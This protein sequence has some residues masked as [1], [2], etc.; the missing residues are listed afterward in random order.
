MH[1]MES[2]DRILAVK[3]ECPDAMPQYTVGHTVRIAELEAHMN[4][5]PGLH[6]AGNA[7]HGIGRSDIRRQAR[8]P[9]RH[10]AIHCRTHGAD[11]RTGSAYE[12][13]SRF[14]SC[15]ECISWNR[16]IGYSPSSASARTP[17]RNTL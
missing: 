2:A 11:R 1:I 13:D 14:A 3:H 4:G 6:L 12:R 10:A 9:G 15:R 7:Y 17:C 5:I 16:Q 8:V